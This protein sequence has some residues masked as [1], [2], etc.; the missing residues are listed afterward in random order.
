MR[1][2]RSLAIAWIALVGCASPTPQPF[3]VPAASSPASRPADVTP[4]AIELYGPRV[5]R[6]GGLLK[7]PVPLTVEE[8]MDAMQRARDLRYRPP[9]E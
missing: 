6:P 4:E 2:L 3:S 5:E 9:G 8:S 1:L 7:K